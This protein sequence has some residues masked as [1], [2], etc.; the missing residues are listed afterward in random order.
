MDS[1][2]NSKRLR[3]DKKQAKKQD[4]ISTQKAA[5]FIT[6]IS[7]KLIACIFDFVSLQDL[8]YCQQVSKLF[9]TNCLKVIQ[10]DQKTYAMSCRKKNNLD[11]DNVAFLNLC[12]Y[13]LTFFFFDLCQKFDP[14]F[15]RLQI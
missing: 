6:K 15:G 12:Y 1:S 14:R 7:I 13:S 9:H 3:I 5:A 10:S 8:V 11:V 2:R 4:V